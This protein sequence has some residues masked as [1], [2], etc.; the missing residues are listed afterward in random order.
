MKSSFL[1]WAAF[2]AAPLTMQAAS[3]DGVAAQDTD[4]KIKNLETQIQELSKQIDDLKQSAARKAAEDRMQREETEAKAAPAPKDAV[5]VSLKNGRPAIASAD[6]NFTAEIRALMQFDAAYYQQNAAAKGLPASYGPDLSS[7]GNFR[8]A[9]IG[10]R[11]TLFGDWSYNF[12]YDFGGSAVETGGHIYTAYLQYD[13]LAPF[14][15]RIGA[16]APP[17]GIEDGTSASDLMFL[18][19]NSPANLARSI[20]GSPGRD[21]VSAIYA[22]KRLFAAVSLTGGKVQDSAVYDEQQAVLGRV[23]GLLYDDKDFSLLVGANGTYVFK[24]PDAAANDAGGRHSVKL[25]DYPELA[26]DSTASKLVNT[27]S[28]AADHYAMWG[29]EAAG[30]FRNVYAQGGYFAYYVDRTQTA[31]TAFTGP[32]AS[33]TV[34]VHPGDDRFSGWYLQASWTLTGEPRT[35]NAANGAFAM[36][37]P[38]R[39]FSLK[40]GGWGAWELAARYSRLDLNDR[41]E[42]TASV[43][44]GWTGAGSKT[45]TY[46]NTVR[47][48]KQKAATIGLNWYPN[49]AVRFLLDYQWIDIDRLQTPGTVTTTGISGLPAVLADQKVQM[50]SLRTQIAM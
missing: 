24:L 13:G 44:T 28:L 42:D 49:R 9:Q 29:L 5:K 2:I 11:G 36:P 46:Y 18:E 20:T 1:V 30:R 47:G 35:Y 25:S 15:L 16:Y 14:A 21:A 43:I 23:S 12:T 39:P 45:Y 31:Y 19:R 41:A 33:D 6:G 40:N 37:K 32:G 34:V 8:R 26:V 3:A 10:L 17:A 38:A 50:L 48:G 7:G 4:A 27:G 22:G